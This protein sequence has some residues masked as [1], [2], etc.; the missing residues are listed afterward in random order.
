M[1][2]IKTARAQTAPAKVAPAKTARAQKVQKTAGI[3]E[4]KAHISGYLR[5]VREGMTLFITDRGRVV[6]E[7]RAPAKPERKGTAEER[8]AEAVANGTIRP[9]LN[10]GKGPR[11]W[12]P[13]SGK[14]APPGTA[15][16]LIDWDRGE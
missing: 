5:D 6:A 16:A 8:Y 14:G 7:V 10:T 4:F 12:P 15:K 11:K 1:P 2:M 3:R 9:P 13:L